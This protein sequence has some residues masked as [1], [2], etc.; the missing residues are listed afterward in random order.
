MITNRHCHWNLHQ[1]LHHEVFCSF[2]FQQCSICFY[3]L[4]KYL[5]N[6]RKIR[7]INIFFFYIKSKFTY[8]PLA[9]ASGG[10]IKSPA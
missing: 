9:A 8:A 4:N 6:I 7:E 10:V 2:S 5:D 1:H 3:H